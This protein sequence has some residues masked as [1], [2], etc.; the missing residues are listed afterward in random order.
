MDI[1]SVD[2]NLLVVFD[3][4]VEHRSVSR[5]AE[6]LGLSQP[7]MSA[8]VGRLRRLFDDPLFVKTGAEMKPTARATEL[9]APVRLVV[10][11]VK[12]EI[13]QAQRF[14]P[15]TAERSFTII[16]PDIA[17][18]KLLPPVL[19]SMAELAPLA[20]L[21]TLSMPRHAAGET[22]ESGVA[23]LAVGYFPDLHKAGYYQQKLFSMQ[24]VC[25]VRRD[26]PTIRSD[27]TLKQYL[28]AS[29]A[30]VSPEGREHVFDQFLY[31]RGLKRRVVLEISHYMSLLPIIESTD[32]VATVPQDLA[33]MC[34][35]HAAIRVVAAPVKS[36]EIEV[37]Q[38]WH[39]RFHK[40]SANV[41]LR[42]LL[43]SLFGST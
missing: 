39:T 31:K 13:L 16:A 18:I 32:L 20:T 43:R 23:E 40:D 25:M 42:A 21:R 26:H 29:H 37:H 1:R 22:L 14:D 27:P 9:S 6:A 12:G 11:T 38:F 28:D 3:A 2:L 10:G 41:W 35:R 24:L 19:A 15:R 8:A 33:E 5:A 4:M 34:A 7:A 17:E 36:P 30:L